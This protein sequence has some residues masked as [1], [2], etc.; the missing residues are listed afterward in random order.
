MH[1]QNM[2]S[3][4]GV[5]LA[6]R[7]PPPVL[8]RL[9]IGAWGHVRFSVPVEARFST[10]PFTLRQRQLILRSISA[11]GST[12]LASR[13][14]S[15]SGLAF[16]RA[17]FWATPN[18]TRSASRSRP[19][20]AFC[21]LPRHVQ[22]VSP[23]AKSDTGIPRLFPNPGS[24]P[25]YLYPSGSKPSTRFQTLKLAFASRPIFFRSPPRSK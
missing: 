3:V 14:Q 7:F 2:A 9:R 4:N 8:G 24:P 22:R 17:A 12:L 6:L 1:G 19:R 15:D 21:R 23:V 18:L 5:T 10:Q 25:G 13:L 11:A 20:P 16:K